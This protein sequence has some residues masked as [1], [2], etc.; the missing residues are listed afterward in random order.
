[1]FQPKFKVC[2]AGVEKIIG[3]HEL[4]KLS[5]EWGLDKYAPNRFSWWLVFQIWM[6]NERFGIE[7]VEIMEAIK[8]L[9]NQ[10]ESLIKKETKFTRYPLKGLWH[11]HYFSARFL[12]KNLQIHHGKD[13]MR[14]IINKHLSGAKEITDDILNPMIAELTIKAFEARSNSGK[15]TGE[16]IVFAK[17]NGENYYLSLG[18]HDGDDEL[19]YQRILSVC[20]PQ[21]K[22]LKDLLAPT[23]KSNEHA[24]SHPPR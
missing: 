17:Y 23:D 13:G 3:I 11:K 15:L 16:W 6:Y 4:S 24:Q 9:E 7:P 5:K 2:S 19:L 14:Q 1:M 8:E 12:P 21:F 20:T 22:F 18:E 10:T